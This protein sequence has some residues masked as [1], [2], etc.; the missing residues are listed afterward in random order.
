[1]P[2]EPKKTNHRVT[3]NPSISIDGVAVILACITC[4]VWFGGLKETVRQHAD[5][6]KTHEIL[7]QTLAKSQELTAQN[8]AVLTTLINERT[9][10][11]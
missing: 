8:I 3:F 1:M 6:L 10:P 4:S 9:K 5:T 7:M 11:K 2:E